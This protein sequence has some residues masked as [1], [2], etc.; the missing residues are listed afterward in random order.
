[1][2]DILPL[3]FESAGSVQNLKCGFG[4]QPRHAAGKT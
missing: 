4:A 2:D 1:M 3:L